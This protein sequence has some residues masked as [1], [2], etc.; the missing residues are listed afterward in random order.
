MNFIEVATRQPATF[1]PLQIHPDAPLALDPMRHLFE[2]PGARWP[3]V[4]ALYTLARQATGSIVEIGTY[5]GCGTI[6]LALGSRDGNQVPVY[7][8]D[9]FT[10]YDGWIGE[11]YTPNDLDI[12]EKNISSLNLT[13]DI[14]LLR[15]T[16]E[17]LSHHWRDPYSLLFWDI[18]GNRLVTDYLDWYPHCAPNGLIAMKD[19][20]SWQFGTQYVLDHA[21]ANGF[22][23]SFSHPKGSIWCIRKT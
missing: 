21:L 9:P 11:H 7:T 1:T 22:E 12:F 6:A 8:I 15:D 19:L 16:C 18:G 5:H 13:S 20:P 17:S 14:T 23:P 3:K 4:L 10:H 2:W